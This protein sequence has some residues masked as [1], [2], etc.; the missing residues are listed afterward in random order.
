MCRR[1]L[2]AFKNHGVNG[3]RISLKG[4]QSRLEGPVSNSAAH[5]VNFGRLLLANKT[6]KETKRP[7]FFFF[8]VLKNG[9]EKT[10][11]TTPSGFAGNAASPP[12]T[13]ARPCLIP[14]P[15]IKY[16]RGELWLSHSLAESPTGK[17]LGRFLPNFPEERPRI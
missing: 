2:E 16:A 3:R 1:T 11:T 10:P 13:K 9:R 15:Q 8:F 12:P 17:H 6:W 7:A 4:M 14:H 5:R